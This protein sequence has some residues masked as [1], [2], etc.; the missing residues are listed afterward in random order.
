LAASAVTLSNEYVTLSA[1]TVSDTTNGKIYTFT[2]TAKASVNG[3]VTFK[4]A[5]NQVADAA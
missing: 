3:A 5:A 2:Y 4:L 1:A